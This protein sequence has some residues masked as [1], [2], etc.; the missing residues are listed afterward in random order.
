MSKNMSIKKQALHPRVGVGVLVVNN[1]MTLLGKRINSHGSGTW[2]LPGGHLEFGETPHDCALRELQE[3]T[4][5]IAKETTKESWTNDFFENEEKH[6]ITLFMIVTKFE[7]TLTLKEPEKCSEWTWFK[8][9]DLPSPL[10]L[11]LKS[12]LKIYEKENPKPLPPR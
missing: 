10:F 11:P 3:E 12:F 5:L 6:Y 1:D 8:F 9:N 7:G 4:G 2:S